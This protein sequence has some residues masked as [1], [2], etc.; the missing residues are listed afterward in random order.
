[1]YQGWLYVFVP[2][3]TQ[4]RPPP[5]PPKPPAAVDGDDGPRLPNDFL[6][7]LFIFSKIIGPEI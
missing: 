7:F 6:D 1:M 4:A 3:R 5:V 2:V